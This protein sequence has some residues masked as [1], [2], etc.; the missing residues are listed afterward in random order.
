MTL[1][2]PLFLKFKMGILINRAALMPF[3]GIETSARSG[4]KC[5]QKHSSTTMVE[6][7]YGYVQGESLKPYATL[8]REVF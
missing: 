2:P 3:R 5:R 8:L 1:R 6:E 4:V 7:A